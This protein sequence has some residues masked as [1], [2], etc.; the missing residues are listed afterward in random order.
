M[1]LIDK[2]LDKY[3]TKKF[4][5]YLEDNVFIAYCLD[6]NYVFNDIGVEIQLKPKEYKDKYYKVY[7]TILY[8]ASLYYL[9]HFDS[10][11]EEFRKN[12]KD[13]LDTFK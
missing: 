12:S 7:H 6:R 10:Y 3:Y 1:K 9:I 11:S 2:Y 8:E 13:F 5:R 4:I